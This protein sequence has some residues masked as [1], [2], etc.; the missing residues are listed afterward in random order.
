MKKIISV[1]FLL[2]FSTFIWAHEFWLEATRFIYQL[3]ESITINLMVGEGFKGDKWKGDHYKTNTI[4]H[5]A[6][7]SVVNISSIFSKKDGMPFQIKA[8]KEGTQMITYNNINKFIELKP[9][10]F[11]AYLKEDGIQEALDYR[12]KNNEQNKNGK[13]LYQRSVKTLLQV[14][15]TLTDDYKKMTDLPVDIIAQSNPYG[16]LTNDAIDF[17][18]YHD[19]KTLA[20]HMVKVWHVYQNKLEHKDV[21][22]NA[23]GLITVPIAKQGKYMISTVKMVRLINDPKADWQSYWASLTF[24]Y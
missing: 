11:E 3:G 19:K 7:D 8:S 5:Y 15:Q 22:S 9:T 17:K 1:L 18:I 4:L 24:G 23:D 12:V 21:Y 13:E 10:E 2:C 20:N 14:G 6:K 16:V